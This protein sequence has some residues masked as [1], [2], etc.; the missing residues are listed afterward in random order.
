MGLIGKKPEVPE[1]GGRSL[2]A[3]EPSKRGRHHACSREEGE[4]S[5]RL[6]RLAPG[7]QKKKGTH[8]ETRGKDRIGLA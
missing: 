4:Q 3:R 5:R 2:T 7:R 8:A 1:K 6:K